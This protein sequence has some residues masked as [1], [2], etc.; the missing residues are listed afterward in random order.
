MIVQAVKSVVPV[1]D[2]FAA[3]QLCYNFLSG[4]NVHS[5]WIAF[6][7]DMYPNEPAEQP[8][9]FILARWACQ[10]RAVSG[11]KSRFECLIKFLRHVDS[12]DDKS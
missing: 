12:T 2:L 1:A 8:I 5:R 9:E 6:Q 7:K 3:L 4:S 10:V 11:I